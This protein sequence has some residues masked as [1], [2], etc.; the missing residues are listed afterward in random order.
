MEKEKPSINFNAPVTVGT[1]VKV[2]QGATYI[3]NNFPNVTEFHEAKEE[4]VREEQ[5]A[6]SD[7]DQKLIRQ[8]TPMFFGSETD[9]ADYLRQIRDM[10]PVQ[11]VEVTN[12]YLRDKKLSEMSSKGTLWEILHNAGLYSCGV[13]NWNKQIK[14]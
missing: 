7:D 14:P 11:V 6:S 8:L 5:P 4:D 12:R 9:A 1:F 13:K 3:K 10:S 2:E